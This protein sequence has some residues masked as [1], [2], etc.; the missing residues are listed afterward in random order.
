MPVYLQLFLTVRRP[1]LQHQDRLAA[2][3][4]NYK[5]APSSSQNAPHC[6]TRYRGILLRGSLYISY[7][8]MTSNT[9]HALCWLHFPWQVLLVTCSKGVNNCNYY[10]S[11]G[12][13]KRT[14]TDLVQ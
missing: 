7:V 9:R 8:Q 13:P 10:R 5:L 12:R 14:R 1:L 11:R 4:I 3:P 2:P 6:S